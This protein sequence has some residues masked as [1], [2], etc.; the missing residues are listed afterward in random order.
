VAGGLCAALAL[1]LAACAGAPDGAARVEEQR[2]YAEALRLASASP[3]GGAAALAAFVREHPQS[4]LADDAALQ[5]AELAVRLGKPEAAERQLDWVLREHPNGDQSDRARLA[6]AKLLRARGEPLLARST[7]LRIRFARLAPPERREAQ[8]LLADLAAEARDPADQLRWL[9]DLASD[10]GPGATGPAVNAE[11]DAVIAALEPERL[12][13][14]AAALGRRAI[15]ARVRLAQAERLLAAGDRKGAERALERAR[16][17]PLGAGDADAL[18]R[19]ETRLAA[20]PAESALA[21]VTSESPFAGAPANPFVDTDGLDATLGV[22]L[23][24]SGPVAEY[25]EDALQGVLLAAGLFDAG[26]ARR[27]GPRLLVRDTRGRPEV[28]AA[29]VSELAAEPGVLAVVGPLLPEES[30]AAAE[31]AQAAGVPL[32]ALARREG[33]ARGK[34]GVLRV[35]TSPRLEA[36]LLAEHAIHGAGH[37]RFAI[38]YPDDAFGL[39]L[40]AAFWDAV[41]A[42]GGEVVAVARYPVGASDFAAP[43]RRMIGYELLPPGALGA[44]AERE[45]MLKRAKRL[46]AAEAAALRDKARALTTSDGA[47]LPPYVDFDAVF[48]PDTHQAAGL[49]APHLAFHEVRGVTLLG[50]S[51]WNHPGLLELGGRHV[52]G[53]VFPGAYSTAIHA[54]NV[55]AFGERFEASF[56]HPASSLAAEAFDAANL[57]LAAA[58]EGADDRGEL[59]E[60]VFAEPR[61]VGVSGVLQIAPD[62]EVARRPHLLGVAGGRVVCIDE[63]GAAP[64]PPA[65]GGSAERAPAASP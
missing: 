6:L 43:I 19:L 48:I 51:A 60:E 2:A 54:P 24:L 41:E 57:A 44:L 53:A 17:L 27:R 25:A 38:L 14:V 16:S 59:L 30:E 36:E 62:G 22:V 49:I 23:P 39:A 47:P 13:G 61:R 63:V 4:A 34:S 52:E 18:V 26:D 21:L 40:R 35:G 45:K 65:D 7:A 56:G 10:P 12:D 37:R 9:G 50:P 11:I 32:L 8:R 31:A 33:L 46:P 64:W 29:A 3:Q 20:K 1:A 15:A 58:A 5:L 28:A 42:R 55:V